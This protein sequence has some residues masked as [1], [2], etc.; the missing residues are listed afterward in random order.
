MAL[1]TMGGSSPKLIK[2]DQSGIADPDSGRRYLS[3]IQY[4]APAKTSGHQVCPF[5]TDGCKSSCLFTAG[6][7]ATNSVQTARVNRTRSFFGDRP[8]YWETL[9]CE[10]QKF[11]NRADRNGFKPAVRLN[12]TSDLPFERLRGSLFDRFSDFQFYDYTKDENRMLRFLSGDFPA[13]YHLTF[14]RSEKNENGCREIL[15]NGGTVA[16]VYR[17]KQWPTHWR[18]FPTIDGDQHDLTFVHPAGHVLALYAKGRAKR[19]D[20][21]FVVDPEPWSLRLPIIGY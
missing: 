16:V 10:L 5:A 9:E 1:L 11:Q 2:S 12:G 13:N 8:E 18:G 14:S 19:D 20:T 4:L 17:G 3:A 7:G 21:G 6:R 15:R